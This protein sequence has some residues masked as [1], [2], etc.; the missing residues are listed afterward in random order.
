MN[1]PKKL[2][3]WNQELIR[4]LGTTL[5]SVS[6]PDKDSRVVILTGAGRA[7]SAG[8]DMEMFAA[9]AHTHAQKTLTRGM[10]EAFNAGLNAPQVFIA[11]I[12]G[13]CVGAAL[14]MAGCCDFRLATPDARFLFPEVKIGMVPAIGVARIAHAMPD[15]MM[16]YLMITGDA[17]DAARAEHD[18]FV[19]YL[20]SA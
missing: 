19:E 2:N 17:Y 12:R 8:G 11:A 20:R 9:P 7:F 4:T 18:G 13:P 10:A 3:A 15:R 1:R 6:G 14:V 16:R 5:E